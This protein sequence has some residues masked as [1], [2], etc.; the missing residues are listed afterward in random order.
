MISFLSSF[1][2]F[3]SSF[4]FSSLFIR[5]SCFLYSFIFLLFSF[6]KTLSLFSKF[7]LKFFSFSSQI[8]S[9]FLLNFFFAMWGSLLLPC[10]CGGSS[11]SWSCSEYG[12]SLALGHVVGV[13]L[14][15]GVHGSCCGVCVVGHRRY[16][17][18]VGVVGHRFWVMLW[19]LF[20]WL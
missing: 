11:A 10:G 3:F 13:G 14:C 5:L 6:L 18:V 16:G 2:Y 15:R 9:L 20:L 7:S 1:L 12:E 4:S 19:V 8:F 17:H